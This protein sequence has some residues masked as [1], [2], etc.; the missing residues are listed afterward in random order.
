[1]SSREPVVSAA[2]VG[3]IVVAAISVLVSFGVPI[4]EDQRVALVGLAG[5]AAPIVIALFQRRKV[6]PLGTDRRGPD[7]ANSDET[8]PR[9]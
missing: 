8:N 4:S 9:P 1:M 5:V 2:V 7:G 6:T 3:A